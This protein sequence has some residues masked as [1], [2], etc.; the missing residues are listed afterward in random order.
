M[1]GIRGA[2]KGK[3]NAFCVRVHGLDRKLS[4]E[5]EG[6]D[7]LTKIGWRRFVLFSS[8]F[9]SLNPASLT[10]NDFILF[11]MPARVLLM[12]RVENS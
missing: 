3:E 11:D 12:S 7:M 4:F 5:V 9:G 2:E 10:P 1:R 8:H 6:R